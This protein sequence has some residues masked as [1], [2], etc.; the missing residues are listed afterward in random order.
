MYLP[1]VRRL[2]S[3]NPGRLIE[4]CSLSLSLSLSLYFEALFTQGEVVSL[5]DLNVDLRTLFFPWP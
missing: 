2:S 3:L 1:C 4:I 5:I